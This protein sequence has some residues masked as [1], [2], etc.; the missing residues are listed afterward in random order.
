[1]LIGQ[2]I[3]FKQ[4]FKSHTYEAGS[5]SVTESLGVILVALNWFGDAL[6]VLLV[7]WHHTYLNDTLGRE[8]ISQLTKCSGSSVIH[9]HWQVLVIPG[10][11]KPPFSSLVLPCLFCT[12]AP[13]SVP[14]CNDHNCRDYTGKRWK[15]CVILVL[16]DRNSYRTE[17]R[18]EGWV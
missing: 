17:M 8:I 4:V 16:K 2:F 3:F 1:M 5:T 18:Q 13:W 11:L 12:L 9:M 7:S 10:F 6:P 14:F 15:S